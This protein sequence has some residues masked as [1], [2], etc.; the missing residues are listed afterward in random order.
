MQKISFLGIVCFLLIGTVS[1]YDWKFG[2]LDGGGFWPTRVSVKIENRGDIPVE[3]YVP[4][5]I[6]D[7]YLPLK[8]VQAESV[9]VFG[10][11]GNE[12]V[13]EL[14]TG[15]NVSCHTGTIPTDSILT[16]PVQAEPKS[17]VVYTVYYN[18]SKSW[19]LP[20][21]LECR[22]TI[23]NG[24]FEK[25][26]GITPIGWCF[27]I[28]DDSHR[29]FLSDE[30]PH[31]GKKCVKTIVDSGATASWIAV[32]QL[33][34]MVESGAK[35]RFSAWVKG[36]NI[37]GFSGWYLHIG[38][39]NNIMMDAP[40]AEAGSGSFDWKQV[41]I[42]FTV[43]KK[44]DRL[45]FGTV[46]RGTGTAWFDSAK[47]EQISVNTVD[48][49]VTVGEPEQAPY[50]A[51]G[52][53]NFDPF[54][55][56]AFDITSYG[57]DKDARFA[58]LRVV[59]N[60]TV[61]KRVG[62]HFN[63]NELQ[64]RFGTPIETLTIL[65]PQGKKSIA[66]R[67][68]DSFLFETES[69]QN[70]IAYYLVV[71]TGNTGSQNKRTLKK[72]RIPVTDGAFPG[73]LEQTNS[74]AKISGMNI[75]DEIPVL[76]TERNMVKNGSF[77][78][79]G[80]MPD[81]WMVN[82]SNGVT[83]RRI[84]HNGGKGVELTVSA[85]A[86]EKWPGIRQSIPVRGGATYFIAYR[87]ESVGDSVPF[88][89]N[90]H[91]LKKDG[92]LSS[93]G[94]CSMAESVKVSGWNMNSEMIHVAND[95][96]QIVLHLTVHTPG[97][98][99]FDDVIM[100]EVDSSTI[101]GIYGG[102]NGVYQVPSIVKVFPDTT[103]PVM[104]QTID[105]KNPA[106]IFAARNETESLQIAFRPKKNG[107]YRLRIGTPTNTEKV[108]LPIP[109]ADAVGYV[110]VDYPTNYYH[111]PDKKSYERMHP[112]VGVGCDGWSGY[113]PDPLI[114]IRSDNQAPAF[115]VEKKYD[116]DSSRLAAAGADELVELTADKTRALWLS[117]TVP[118]STKPGEYS[119]SIILENIENDE[120]LTVPYILHVFDVE[121]PSTPAS[122]AIYD[123]H[124][125][126][127]HV[128]PG[129]ALE[130]VQKRMIEFMAERKLSFNTIPSVP[131]FVYDKKT[132][133]VSCD[134]TEFDK[135]A[136]WY[137]D[138]IHVRWSY[139]PLS[140]FYLFGWGLPPKMI[141]DEA[142]YN[143]EYPYPDADRAVLRPE[144][145][146][147]Y[148]ACLTCFWNHVKE[149]GWADRFV[150]YISD[151]PFFSRP[152]IITQM[153]VL[154]AMVHEVDPEIKIYSSTWRH[155]PEWDGSLDVW[156]IGH[157]GI[158]EPEQLLKSKKRNDSFWWTTDGQMCLDT[159][160][161]AIERLLP[162]WCWRWNADAYEFWGANW[163]TYNPFDYGWHRY[164][165]QTDTPTN[166]Y[167][168]RY[169]N[170]DGYIFY[171]GRLI[172]LGTTI[173]SSVRAEAARDGQED[174]LL[175]CLLDKAIQSAKPENPLRVEAEKLRE[176]AASLVPIPV[177]SGRYSTR[178]LS[179]PEQ[180]DYLRIRIGEVLEA[181]R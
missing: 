121:L 40:M 116:N 16:I 45:D 152:E 6:G 113:W 107:I 30:N 175:L 148:Q 34:T 114:P 129:E 151:E 66:Q 71:D 19:H 137:F 145:K 68:N 130:V 181:L 60:D 108:T 159:P 28:Q 9:R 12:I 98:Y 84:A 22:M 48:Y 69:E 5:K 18:N 142:P 80:E 75:G 24:D 94:M 44:A 101:L 89:L 156:G 10:P 15:D 160:Y 88:R 120:V 96:E 180:I 17:V 171:P 178:F 82:I 165:P 1:A 56:N 74:T 164:I 31:S 83:I 38:N 112:T 170:G 11:D 85:E 73:T 122:G 23:E 149:K 133:I 2:T 51:I 90:Y 93:G 161:C 140:Q 91:Q 172:G 7:G 27:D 125:L 36:E 127:I 8:G 46:L 3:K 81:N 42:E 61:A 139:M 123:L 135:V 134:W 4:I 174:A 102:K 126:N 157:Y 115:E 163:F 111:Y 146:K 141:K 106:R 39:A 52:P 176:E 33:N 99:R 65:S 53:K 47:L 179:D 118:A 95:T 43:P 29:I 26:E 64:N 109:R 20:D 54:N 150:L 62:I 136:K 103:F 58:L 158:V 110:P 67:W 138:E 92:S 57:F 169:P 153:K 35:Y 104:R 119:S 50:K 14:Q 166:K 32:R 128:L 55:P 144:F 77:E 86:A 132:G 49:T 70:S 76:F 105:A 155:L 117:F 37:V 173:I 154:C 124:S 177:A 21:W 168:V 59:S 143:G 13:F 100:F 131:N 63:A 78:N 97:T 41:S 87:S 167:F 147:A 72:T 25:F 79:G 162:W